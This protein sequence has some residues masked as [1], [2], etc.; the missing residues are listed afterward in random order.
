MLKIGQAVI[1]PLHRL[2]TGCPLAKRPQFRR[3]F[4]RQHVPAPRS[5]CGSIPPTAGAYVQ[6]KR[7]LRGQV[8]EP[9][10]MNILKSKALVLLKEALS[11]AALGIVHNVIL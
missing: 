8:S 9:M 11:M 2:A 10:A 4:Y 1:E 3:W 6:S 7:R 5:Q